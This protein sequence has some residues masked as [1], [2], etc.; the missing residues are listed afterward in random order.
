[1]H[2]V[3]GFGADP[4]YLHQVLSALEATVLLAVVDNRLGQL[5]ADAG[6]GI[7][8]PVGGS[9]DVN[10]L[11]LGGGAFARCRNVDLDACQVSV[12]GG[13]AGCQQDIL[14]GV[15][16]IEVLEAGI[17]YGPIDINLYLLF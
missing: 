16:P 5:G 4:L 2:L 17:G 3:E 1:M 9:I 6:Q 15:C 14:N 11:R 13:T 7:E 12:V 8:Q 10:P